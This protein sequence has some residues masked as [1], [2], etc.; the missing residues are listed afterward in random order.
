MPENK[1][2]FENNLKELENVVKTL[3]SG[4]VS[5]DEMLT[6]YEK[7][8]SL[9]KAC[10]SALDEAEQKINVL[11]KNRETGELEA[12]PFKGMGE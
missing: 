11:T 12:Q 4:E 3:E 8:I 5:L 9:T 1:Q 2:S 10:T 6:L 7:G